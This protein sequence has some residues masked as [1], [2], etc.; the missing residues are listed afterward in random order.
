M[1]IYTESNLIELPDIEIFQFLG[2]SH[3]NCFYETFGNDGTIGRETP[4]HHSQN[5]NAD[6]APINST[7]LEAY[8][9]RTIKFIG[10][11]F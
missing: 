6:S 5:P 8:V 4:Y 2:Y 7:E 3:K 1:S 9:K 11:I 10:N